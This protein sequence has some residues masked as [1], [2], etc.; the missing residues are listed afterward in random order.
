M[1]GWVSGPPF[2]GASGTLRS[3][4]LYWAMLGVGVEDCFGVRLR[5]CSAFTMGDLGLEWWHAVSD[6]LLL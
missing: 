1:R 6:A 5:V 3:L 2:R 4:V